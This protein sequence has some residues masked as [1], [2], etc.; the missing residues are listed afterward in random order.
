MSRSGFVPPYLLRHVAEA[1]S[2]GPAP[3][4]G[5]REACRH[6]LD[7]DAGFRDE[8]S[9]HRLRTQAA[10]PEQP[11]PVETT[12]L[13]WTI[14]TA[15]NT[16]TLPGEPV[17]DET[18]GS[19]SG[20]LPVDEAW[21]GV[22][23]TLDMLRDA[24]GRT[25][26]DDAGARVSATVHYG[27]NYQNAFWDGR[28]L[29]FGD[30]DGQ[31]FNRF[32][33]AVDILAHELG[34]AV[35]EHTAGLVYRNQP[36][37][38]NES[39]SD[40]FGTCLKQRV[41]G[42]DAAEADWLIGEGLFTDHVRG[43]AL[44][45]MSEPGTAYDDPILGK[46][47]QPA[48]MD[49]FVVTRDDNG[50]VH[51]NSGIPNRAFYLA[52]TEIGGSSTEGAGRIWYDALLTV[53]PTTDFA[54]FAAATVAVAGEHADVVREA[55]ASVGVIAE[56]D[57]AQEAPSD[58]TD[59]QGEPDAPGTPAPPSD[60]GEPIGV[61]EVRRSG[62]FAGI[63]MT[64]SLDLDGDDPRVGEARTLVHRVDIS[65]LE[66]EAAAWSEEP[67]RPDAFTY[68]IVCGGHEV[69]VPEDYATPDLLRLAELILAS[70]DR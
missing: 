3:E 59:D 50:G 66:H 40:V 32:T 47:P 44:R 25:S 57:G 24:F 1:A 61:V 23:D 29:V 43:D 51:I 15:G 31:I 65:L 33:I 7:L 10:E 53:G 67:R 48:H 9:A 28:Q 13:A 54:G 62:G 49:D 30:G 58:R 35:T 20:D 21:D 68:V 5:L 69:E 2:S 12:G 22:R 27:Q 55:W 6:T 19:P 26:Y 16:Q 37:A 41:L 8:R 46:D 60:T 17:R 34:H 38:L 42:Q 18:D 4:P 14:H 56:D 36:G 70:R 63:T 64:S 52:A 11:R 39:M 45:S